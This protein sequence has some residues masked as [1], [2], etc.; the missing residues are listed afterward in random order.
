ML[1]WKD[2]PKGPGRA[3]KKGVPGRKRVQGVEREPNGRA[4]RKSEVDG[5]LVYFLASDGVTF[6]QAGAVKVG[7][8]GNIDM[9]VG[10]LSVGCPV[11]LH[12]AGQI[13]A[14]CQKIARQV[15]KQA[16]R[17]LKLAGRHIRGEWFRLSLSEVDA[18]ENTLKAWVMNELIPKWASEAA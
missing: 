11:S 16:H 2:R 3:P 9:R 1:V 10:D 13:G 17:S 14:P 7:V 12:L 8:T 4:S 15:E 5:W 18:L 6:A